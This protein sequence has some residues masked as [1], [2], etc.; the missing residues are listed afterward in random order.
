MEKYRRAS[1]IKAGVVGYSNAFNMG[2]KQ[3]QEMQKAGMTPL[4]V[5]E[6]DAARLEA[7]RQDFPGI[8][9]YSR[10]DEMLRNPDL[11]LVVLITPHNLH[12]EQAIQCLS[13]GK[14][15]ICEKPFAITTEECDAM[16][17]K[18]REMDLMLTT[19]HNRHWDPGILAAMRVLQDGRI[20]EVYKIEANM[21]GWN[22]PGEWWRSSKSISGGILYDW[23]VHL[24]EYC[25]QIFADAKLTEVCGFARNGYW[26]EQIRWGADSNEDEGYLVARFDTGQWLRLCIT[27]IDCHLKP[28]GLDVSGTR[29]A[30][31]VGP[32]TCKAIWKTDDGS[33]MTEEF[34]GLHGDH[35]KF[36][37]NIAAHLVDGEPLII[38]PEW[39]RR[40]IHIIDLAGQSAKQGRA[41]ASR[42]D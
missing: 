40:P 5:C 39:A 19:Y 32:G 9:T 10:M 1:D 23:G 27:S 26:R 14:H 3:L 25:L 34:S 15:V 20:G 18:S 41:L 6:I 17:A 7:A 11:D 24:L 33:T 31:V 28:S 42:Y 8:A 12:A 38:T 35:D 37:A 2:R 29:G 30:L 36:Y 21:G 16:I 4:A 22:R 13:A